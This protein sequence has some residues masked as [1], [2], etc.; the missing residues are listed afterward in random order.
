MR[1]ACTV[2]LAITDEATERGL[3]SLRCMS[4]VVA[5]RVI[6]LSSRISSLSEHS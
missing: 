3:T 2:V 1:S 4:P 5:H 6:S